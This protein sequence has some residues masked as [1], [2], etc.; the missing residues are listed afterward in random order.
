MLLLLLL[1]K[2]LAFFV[3]LFLKTVFCPSRFFFSLFLAFLK[4]HNTQQKND[5]LLSK[6][7]RGRERFREREDR[8]LA[9]LKYQAVRRLGITAA[10]KISRSIVSTKA[11]PRSRCCVLS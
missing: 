9:A 8:S 3:V 4:N 5:S 6:K 7:E 2:T 10:H 11:F 1:L